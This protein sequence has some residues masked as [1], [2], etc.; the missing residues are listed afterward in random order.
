LPKPVFDVHRE[1]GDDHGCDHQHWSE[2]AA[3][4]N[5]DQQ[6]TKPLTDARRDREGRARTEAEGSEEAARAL[7]PVAAIPTE[8]LLS[9]V[10]GRREADDQAYE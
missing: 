4:A 3:E 1:D 5:N 2:R 10:C 7:D 9:A 6:T 8:K